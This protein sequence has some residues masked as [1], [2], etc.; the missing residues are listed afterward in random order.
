MTTTPLL[1]LPTPAAGPRVDADSP[2]L[3][4]LTEIETRIVSLLSKMGPLPFR[5]L[6]RLS[7][8]DRQLVG[9]ALGRLQTSGK[10]GVHVKRL[11]SGNHSMPVYRVASHQ[12]PP[13][14][15]ASVASEGAQG[16]QVN[17]D[18]AGDAV[19]DNLDRKKPWKIPGR[20]ASCAPVK[21]W[22]Q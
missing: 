6:V 9:F 18:G 17:G 20:C 12:S 14:P 7:G 3:N 8:E 15:A 13:A 22:F 4:R 2:W 1:P 5:A 10:V 21:G 19:A 11:V 16:G